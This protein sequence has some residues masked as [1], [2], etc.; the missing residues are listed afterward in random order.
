MR[1]LEVRRHSL[2]KKGAAR[3]RGS[4]LSAEG[5][6]LAR[7]VG[8]SLGPFARVVTSTSPRAIETAL[9]MGF[10]VDDTV[11]LPSGDVPGEV[12]HHDQWRWPRPFRTYAELL[13]RGGRLAAAQPVARCRRRP[14][15]RRAGAVPSA[16]ARPARPQEAG[17]TSPVTYVELNTPDL[18]AA[19]RFFAE[20]FGWDPQPFASARAARLRSAA[21]P[22]WRG[23]PCGSA[24]YWSWSAPGTG[25]RTP[26]P[27]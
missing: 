26:A 15:G 10:A 24:G 13:G 7:F 2:T 17:M 12:E 19:S 14:G 4:H 16:G 18:P 23:S 5:V 21:V 6:A 22:P 20:V 27:T 8:A 11:E 9:A 1:W 3:D 25:W